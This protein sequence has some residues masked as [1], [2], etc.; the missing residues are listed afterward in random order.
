MT[1]VSPDTGGQP[2]PRSDKE[3]LRELIRRTRG[4]AY[5]AGMQHANPKH[6]AHVEYHAALGT[7]IDH[8]DRSG[9]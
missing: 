2:E 5:R 3:T 4:A 1:S 7:L 8:L 6:P 9:L